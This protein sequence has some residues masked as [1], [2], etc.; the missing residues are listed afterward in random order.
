M[1]K[2]NGWENQ[3][4]HE[5]L[6]TLAERMEEVSLSSLPKEE[7][8]ATL[9]PLV[10]EFLDTAEHE[11]GI[12]FTD[13]VSRIYTEMSREQLLARVERI[14]RIASCLERGESIGVGSV[15]DHYANSVTPDPE[16]L[17][18]AM[19]EADAPG[20]LRIMVGLDLKAMV[21]FKNDHV[22]VHE[23]E[24][25]A[26]DLRDTSLRAAYCRHVVGEIYRDD[27]RYLILR[28]PRQLF[29]AER[30]LE[31]ERK[32]PTPFVF[33]AS[34]LRATGQQEERAAA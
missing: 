33:R 4:S 20:P 13:D 17:R 16:G 3:E 6:A 24:D 11:L 30:L 32:T 18:I 29:P 22:E 12:S 2:F 31:A 23:I 5:A 9:R 8:I 1:E 10:A 28:I 34:K 21:G 14:S 26:F 25:D 7:M 15:E 27:I 19:A